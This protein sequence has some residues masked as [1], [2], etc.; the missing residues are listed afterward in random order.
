MPAHASIRRLGRRAITCALG[1]SLA[2]CAYAAYG[3]AIQNNRSSV[4]VPATPPIGIA[5]TGAGQVNRLDRALRHA[6]EVARHD[7]LAEGVD[8]RVTSGWR[9][10][11]E[12]AELFAAAVRHYGSADAASHWVLPPG[13][14]AHERGEAIDVGPPSA[15]A[16]LDT[17]GVHYGLCRR[18][19]NEPWHF[20]LLAPNLGEPC[21][22]LEPHARAST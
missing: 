18:Y 8:L 3:A 4:T 12:Q 13:Q 7:A 2:S 9:S 21:P 22:H 1:A 17:H 20:E 6:Y 16:W 10:H 19:A 11:A 14:S 5:P 15:A